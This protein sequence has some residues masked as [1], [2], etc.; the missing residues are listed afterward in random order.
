MAEAIK[1][2]FH[3]YMHN[4]ERVYLGPCD[5]TDTEV[6]KFLDSIAAIYSDPKEPGVF[7]VRSAV[8]DARAFAGVQI[9]PPSKS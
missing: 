7:N 5:M 4:G 9:L 8:F 1:R 2:E 3:G 6:Q